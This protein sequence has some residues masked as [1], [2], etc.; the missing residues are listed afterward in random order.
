MPAGVHIKAQLNT[1]VSEEAHALIRL[2]QDRFGLSQSG[3]IEM[4]LREKARADKISLRDA[5]ERYG[6]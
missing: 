2:F 4:L 3:V 5:M 6:R 1:R